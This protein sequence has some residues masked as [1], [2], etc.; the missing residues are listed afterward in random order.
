MLYTNCIYGETKAEMNYIIFF[1]L[2]K[3]S[4]KLHVLLWGITEKVVSGCAQCNPNFVQTVM[5]DLIV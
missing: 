2:Q 3:Y 5:A 4:R 1:S